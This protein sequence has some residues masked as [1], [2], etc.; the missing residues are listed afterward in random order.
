[1]K[2]KLCISKKGQKGIKLIAQGSH[3]P[4]FRN[5]LSGSVAMK[6]K[7]CMMNPIYCTDIS[8]TFKACFLGLLF[9]SVTQTSRC[10]PELGLCG[11]RVYKLLS[12]GLQQVSVPLR[13]SVCD[14]LQL[15]KQNSHW[16]IKSSIILKY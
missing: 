8:T 15:K 1:M 3:Y 10:S 7:I 9:C 12:P 6:C 5:R 16:K 11:A 13:N 14:A 4:H 2:I